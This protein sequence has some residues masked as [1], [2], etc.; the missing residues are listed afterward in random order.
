MRGDKLE[1][2]AGMIQPPFYTADMPDPVM[3]G[4]VGQILAHEFGH[5]LDPETLAAVP[6]W[7][8]TPITAAA[9][10]ARVQC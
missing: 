10:A 3:L 5:I 4:A 6:A 8:P 7:R 9:Y 1:L 2:F